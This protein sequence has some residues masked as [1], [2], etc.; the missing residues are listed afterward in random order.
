MSIIASASSMGTRPPPT[1][2]ANGRDVD[3]DDVDEPDAMLRQAL[4]VGGHVAAGEDAGVDLGM[5][6]LDLAAD[7]RWCRGQGADG[8]DLHAIRRERLTGAVGGE[9]L[10]PLVEQVTSE[11]GDPGAIGDREQGT[12]PWSSLG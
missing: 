11:V 8:V 2:G 7:D 9:H 3:D 12:H 6:R 5:E 10:D 1:W 4:E